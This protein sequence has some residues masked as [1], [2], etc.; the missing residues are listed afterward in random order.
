MNFRSLLLGSAAALVAVGSARAADAVVVAEPEPVEYVRVCD[1][2]GAG[3]FYIPGTETCL[4]ISGEVY[5]QIGTDS[6]VDG[7]IKTTHAHVD[8]DARSQTEWGTLRSLIRLQSEWGDPS[9]G[10]VEID[11]AILEIGGLRMGYTESAWVESQVGEVSW[12]GSHS[13]TALSYGDQQRHQIAYSFQS[14]NGF[15]GTLSLEDDA[16]EGDG[17]IP[18]V[19]GLAGVEQGWGGAWA[20]VGYDQSVE[21]FGVTAGLQLNVPNMEGSSFRL[22]GFYSSGSGSVVDDTN[23]YA[24]TPYLSATIG[25]KWSVLASYNQQFSEN[26]GA[27][28]GAQYFDDVGYVDGVSAWQAE[29]SLVWTPIE[30]FEVRGEVF[31]VNTQ[32]IDVEDSATGGFLRFTRFF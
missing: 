22:L 31:H 17:Y 1:V 20:K 4:Q 24:V 30:N 12:G 5:Y 29:L 6:I 27:S 13:D 3:F 15:F 8:F 25:S 26:F 14:Q 32:E 21:E 23:A 10:P 28:I 7:W 18:D 9:D 19:V 11:Q 2:Y 16:L